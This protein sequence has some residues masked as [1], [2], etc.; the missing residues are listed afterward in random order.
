MLRRSARR[1]S[2]SPFKKDRKLA[3]E[4]EKDAA[5][6]LVI[7]NSPASEFGGRVPAHSPQKGVQL[8]SVGKDTRDDATRKAEAWARMERQETLNRARYDREKIRAQLLKEKQASSRMKDR[9]RQEAVRRLKRMKYRERIKKREADQ[10]Q[11]AKLELERAQ[12][13][14]QA[15]ARRRVERRKTLVSR[16]STVLDAQSVSH[17]KKIES[18]TRGDPLFT[19]ENSAI[20]EIY[21]QFTLD[22]LTRLQPGRWLNQEI[23]DWYLSVLTSDSRTCVSLGAEF[24]RQLLMKHQGP[25][26]VIDFHRPVALRGVEEGE[27]FC[28][29]EGPRVILVPANPDGNHWVLIAI[30]TQKRTVCCYDSLSPGPKG[31]LACRRIIKRIMSWI[32][33]HEKRR[34]GT[35]DGWTHEMVQGLP[36]QENTWDCGVHTCDFARMVSFDPPKDP[37][38]TSDERTNQFRARLL[39]YALETALISY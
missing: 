25:R 20:E 16:L 22:H 3:D 8:V 37:V 27:R 24:H 7:L 12:K 29:L 35:M 39:V 14:Q 5:E 11:K 38:C 28:A 1:A 9:E 26:F 34:S 23:I 10:V 2:G 32:A 17:D 6:T 31:T 19:V 4:E 30:F 13:S 21:V 33:L 18:L 36:R 15:A